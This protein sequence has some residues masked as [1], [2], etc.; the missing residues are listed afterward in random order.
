MM[1]L[2]PMPFVF[3]L[4]CGGAGP[5]DPCGECNDALSHLTDNLPGNGCNPNWMGEA[6]EK[7]LDACGDA[8]IDPYTMIGL[9]HE[10]CQSSTY[11]TGCEAGATTLAFDIA[12]DPA[13]AAMF[14]DGAR[15]FV[16]DY[17]GFSEEMTVYETGKKV[18]LPAA[19]AGTEVWVSVWNT[20]A[21]DDV[22][23]EGRDVFSIRTSAEGWDRPRR[24]VTLVGNEEDG[25]VTVR[26]NDF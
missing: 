1:Y 15:V 22:I 12:L 8:D 26:F 21:N 6:V 10:A 2:R 16:D 23:G 4:A 14:P 18:L 13:A 5:D 25:T 9:R 20:P 11:L 24:S 17:D 19:D 3:F 7:V